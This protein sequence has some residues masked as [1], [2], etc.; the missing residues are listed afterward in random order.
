M[1]KDQPDQVTATS[2]VNRFPV[3]MISTDMSPYSLMWQFNP[4]HNF[5]PYFSK[6]HLFSHSYLSFASGLNCLGLLMKILCASLISPRNSK[7][8]KKQRT[9]MS[10]P[11]G[12]SGCRKSILSRMLF[13]MVST[14]N[15]LLT[16]R[17]VMRSVG[18]KF[19]FR[20]LKIGGS[21]SSFICMNPV[22]L[23]KTDIWKYT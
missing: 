2:V 7:W 17:W 16:A 22:V 3:F 6:L 5:T 23:C 8:V 18:E 12:L 4:I 11:W 10:L 20:L 19:T 21:S 13:A 9:Q 1:A 14:S 15:S